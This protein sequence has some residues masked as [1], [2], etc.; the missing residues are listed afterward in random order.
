MISA[1]RIKDKVRRTLYQKLLYKFGFGNRVAK[2]TWET[3]FEDGFWNYLYSKEE[4][5][6]Y[7][8]IVENYHHLSPGGRI[9]DIGSGNGALYAYL[10]QSGM[11]TQLYLGIDIAEAAVRDAT[12]RFPKAD[13]KQLDFEKSS[14]KDRFNVIVFNESLYYFKRPLK[15]V[16]ECIKHNLKPGGY[17][18]IS[19]VDYGKNNFLWTLLKKKYEF[20]RFEDVENEQGQRWKIG[21][22][23]PG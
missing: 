18:I 11:N 5:A 9:L 4:M 12:L 1:D 3:Q 13:F 23:S 6:H 20:I 22:I 8:K 10:V 7:L 15:K 21:V 2:S 17:L 14:L 16:A 19:I